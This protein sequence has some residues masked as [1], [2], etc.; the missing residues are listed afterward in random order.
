[1]L[2]TSIQTLADAG[3]PMRV[4]AG[5]MESYLKSPLF[6]DN[7]FAR[8]LAAMCELLAHSAATHS[9]PDFRITSTKVAGQSVAVTEEVM[10][11]H[12]FC[13]L[14]HF[15]KDSAV[16]QPRVLFV[17]PLSGHFATL[18]RGTVEAFLPD[19][20]VYITDWQNARDVPLWYGTFGIEDSI[21]VIISHLAHLGPETHVIA[22]CQPAITTLA[23]ISIISANDSHMAPR[24]MTLIGG[25]IDTQVNP[26]EVNRFAQ[27]HPLDWFRRHVISTVPLFLLGALRPVYPG[28]LQLAGFLS[29][30]IDKH[31]KAH[32]DMFDDM[33]RGDGESAAGR[34]AFYDEYTAVMDL[35][36]D[37]YL[38]TIDRVFHRQLLA[39]GRFPY[40]NTLVDPGAVTRTACLTIEGELDDICGIGQTRAAH[41]LLTNLGDAKKTYHLQDGVGHYGTF[42]GKRFQSGVYPVIRDFVR[43]HD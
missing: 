23:A 8:Q 33:V 19:H 17:A 21:D 24:S 43:A 40:R 6:D 10:L 37:F 13:E 39:R 30:N 2:Y 16:V 18:L 25:P 36:A 28:F 35:P 38:D 11:R 4:V 12:P 9:R 1:M 31:V 41:T 26:T 29:M 22:V 3:L 32:H 27:K 42:N 5:H 14:L 7:P 15:R 20:D 34:R